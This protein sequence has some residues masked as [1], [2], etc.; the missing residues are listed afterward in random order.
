MF[1]QGLAVVIKEINMNN[2]TLSSYNIPVID[3][4]LDLAM[5]VCQ[6]RQDGRKGV[7]VSDYLES[8]RRGNVKSVISAIFAEGTMPETALRQGMR[9]VAAIYAEVEE[10]PDILAV[11]RSAEEV[12]KAERDGKIAILLSFEGAEP[13]GQDADILRLFYAL[14]VRFLGLCWSRRNYAADGANYSENIKSTGSGLTEFGQQLVWEAERLGMLIDVSHLNDAGFNDLLKISKRP[15]I[16][17]H[18]NCR[19]IN[20]T[21][22]NLSDGQ[23]RA[24][25]DR[26]GV[27]GINACS[28]LVSDCEDTATVERL[29]DHVDHMVRLAGIEHISLGFDFFEHMVPPG[30]CLEVNGKSVRV[31]DVIKR[32]SDIDALTDTLLHRG[33]HEEEIGLIYADNMR[34]VL[35]AL[36]GGGQDGRS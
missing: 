2:R 27:I 1:K 12:L 35:R 21:K 25:A 36:G 31:F 26:G 11:C 4:H 34:R 23:I 22:R 16:A 13:L 19:A 14:G 29:A 3:A 24:I 5:D 33:Y 6:K 15:F 10:S 20:G 32:H 28:I 9:Q 30:T 17:S 18:S 7:I 8:F